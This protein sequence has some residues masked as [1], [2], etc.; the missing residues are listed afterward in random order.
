[1]IKNQLKTA[2]LLGLLTGLLLWVGQLVGGNSGLTF[3]LLFSILMNFGAYWWS[4]KIVLAMYKAKEATKTSHQELHLIIEDI[5]RKAKIP[6]PKLYIIPTH[7][8]NAFATGPNPKRA[9]VACTQGILQLLDKEELK[10]V[11]A[12]ELSHIK[13]RDTLIS[14][15]AATI[16]GVISYIAYMAQWSAIFGGRDGERENNIVGLL[17]LVVL[18]PILATIIQLAISRSREYLAD[19]SAARTLRNS[20]GL[21]T[22]LQ[23]I[24]AS[25]HNYPLKPSGIT[26]STAHLFISNPFKNQ[27]LVN[28]FSTHPST[29]DRIKRLK[30]VKL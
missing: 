24:E 12:H 19:E 14:T 16:A 28:L 6:K 15:I 2:L 9:T 18:T 26:E 8:A 29:A 20:N 25:V 10:G 30:E 23:K 4:D 3:M 1:M 13:N 27:G 22:A 21:I 17:V 11:L 5:A 7:Q